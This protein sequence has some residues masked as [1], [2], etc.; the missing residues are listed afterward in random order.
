MKILSRLSTFISVLFHSFIEI[1]RQ[2]GQGGG[3]GMSEGDMKM[4]KI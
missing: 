3:Q 1:V 2:G 4:Y